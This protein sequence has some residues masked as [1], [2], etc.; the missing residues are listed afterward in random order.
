MCD[1]NLRARRTVAPRQ[2]PREEGGLGGL[3]IGEGES[4]ASLLKNTRCAER[5]FFR[6]WR[7]FWNAGRVPERVFGVLRTPSVL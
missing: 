4:R 3:A 2:R 7:V 5:G 1:P 6:T